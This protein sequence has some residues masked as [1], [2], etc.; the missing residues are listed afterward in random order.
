MGSKEAEEGGDIVQELEPVDVSL[1]CQLIKCRIA[2]QEDEENL[3]VNM[4]CEQL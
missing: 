4:H 2:A 3:H 1:H